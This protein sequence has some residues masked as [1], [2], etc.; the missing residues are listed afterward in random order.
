[1]LEQLLRKTEAAKNMKVD[2][3]SREENYL[4]KGLPAIWF[5]PGKLNSL[6]NNSACPSV[7]LPPFEERCTSNHQMLNN[8]FLAV[9]ENPSPVAILNMWGAWRGLLHAVPGKHPCGLKELMSAGLVTVKMSINSSFLFRPQQTVHSCLDLSL[10]LFC[11]NR[12]KCPPDAY[13]SIYW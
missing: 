10:N 7:A 3:A 12:C 13:K 9:V 11:L 5:Y 8:G 1:M 4:F 6:L 2:I